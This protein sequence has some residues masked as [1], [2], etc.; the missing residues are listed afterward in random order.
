[1]HTILY[2]NRASY[3]WGLMIKGR[4]TQH[5]VDFE[6]GN[7][8]QNWKRW[9]QTMR[10]MLQGPLSKKDEKQQ[11]GYFLLYV[12]Q[13]GRDIYNT[14]TLTSEETDKID[15]LFEKY[16]A[17][18]NPKQNVTVI[19][20]KFKTRNQSDGETVDQYVTELKRIAKDCA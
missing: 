16:E 2:I 9:K 17:Y 12:G 5:G 15:V 8:A 3:V 6:N 10:L 4:I 19:R 13:N 1:M 7:I 18:C 14:W 20:Y 11:C